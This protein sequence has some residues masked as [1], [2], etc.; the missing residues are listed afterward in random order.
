MDKI[1]FHDRADE[2]RASII[3]KF[4]GDLVLEVE[5]AF[6]ALRGESGG[7]RL[8]IDIT[9]IT[10]YDLAGRKLL[11]ELHH[12]GVRLAAGTPLSL[13]FLQEI[14]IPMRPAE[15]PVPKE[16]P[17]RKRE[18]AAPLTQAHAAAGD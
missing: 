13:V 3:G 6:R 14:S 1:K 10:G 9:H 2:F 4:A 18:G 5:R 16:K 12:Y 15:P 7:R 11:Q 17:N 8:T